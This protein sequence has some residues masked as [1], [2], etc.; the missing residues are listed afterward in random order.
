MISINWLKNLA[1]DKNS[2]FGK[3]P[4]DVQKLII[5]KLELDPE[6]V[7]I[8]LESE[9]KD[10]LIG[11]N[12]ELWRS[13]WYRYISSIIDVENIDLISLKKMFKDA[14]S[15]YKINPQFIVENDNIEYH[16]GVHEP[17]FLKNYKK[18][19]Y[20]IINKNSRI[21]YNI[22][23]LISENDID[24]DKI[25]TL[26]NEA[27]N[28]QVKSYVYDRGVFGMPYYVNGFFVQNAISR[29]ETL[30]KIF[31][32][33]G[34]SKLNINHMLQRAQSTKKHSF[35]KLL[36]NNGADINASFPD[37]NDFDA[38]ETL[39]DILIEY[40]YDINKINSFGNTILFYYNNPN[41]V[42][43]IIKKSPTIINIQNLEG[44][45][46]LHNA[47]M[48]T[49]HGFEK[50]LNKLKI[51]IDNGADLFI[52]NNNKQN[53]L[54]LAYKHYDKKQQDQLSR[55]LYNSMHK[56]SPSNKIYVDSGRLLKN[57]IENINHTKDYNKEHEDHTKYN[58]DNKK[59]N[60]E[61]K[62]NEKENYE[63][64]NYCISI[65]GSGNKCKNKAING[66]FYCR[67]KSHQH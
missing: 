35:T 6:N 20:D 54:D 21:I 46:A 22:I 23:N 9:D 30:L 18:G 37:S 11:N 10:Y 36:L 7:K 47:I 59:E 12:I 27:I 62:N 31:L 24:Y 57:R 67:I 65:T 42:E 51:L 61:K 19:N 14:F 1:K 39:F 32:E 34:M 60:N 13:L 50:S 38:D 52:K 48:T 8:L 41:I 25:K 17:D 45:T 58:Q 64:K 5:G 53:P 26:L 63:K 15:L 44:N 66:S 3:I 49:H 40:N 16:I 43:K 33:H 28:I 4:R 56:S 55:L 29:D 2:E